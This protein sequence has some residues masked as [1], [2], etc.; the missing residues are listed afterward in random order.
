MAQKIYTFDEIKARIIGRG[1]KSSKIEWLKNE[2]GFNETDAEATYRLVIMANPRPAPTRRQ[3]REVREAA[4]ELMHFTVGVELEC[5][6]VDR[7]RVRRI[8]SERGIATH[9]DYNNYN[10]RD[11]RDSYK[12]MSDGSLRRSRGDSYGTCEIVTPILNDLASLKTVCEI[13]NEAGA[14]VNKSCGLHVHF[15][16]STFTDAQWRRIICNYGR[17]EAIIDGFM[18]ASRRGD[19]CGWCHTI[20]DHARVIERM[21]SP[22]FS[23]MRSVVAYGDAS[24]AR[25]HKVNLE[26][27]A[28]HHTIEFRQ[29]AGTI[30]FAKIENWVKF[31]AGLLTYS[32]KNEALLEARTLNDLPFLTAEQKAFFKGR[33][34]RFAERENREAVYAEAETV[35]NRPSRCGGYSQ[36]EAD[37]AGA[38]AGL[39]M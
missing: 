39:P 13:L 17:I 16:A 20:T 1:S 14:K 35:Y 26:A 23:Q 29:H 37:L 38:F 7:G 34:N 24:G 33:S 28:R 10:H 11:S 8:C 15:G 5:T 12:L 19:G 9:D 36:R 32:I 3:R 4:F 30:D 22:T 31:L 18:P 2:A 21:P 25:Y 6:N 27:F